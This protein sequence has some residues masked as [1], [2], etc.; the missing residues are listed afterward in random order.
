MGPNN[1]VGRASGFD[2]AKNSD[3]NNIGFSDKP[4]SVVVTSWISIC[5]AIV[6]SVL[7]WLLDASTT[8]SYAT[9]QKQKDQVIASINSSEYTQIDQKVSGF[10]SAY[11]EIL[12]ASADKFVMNVFLSSLYKVINTDV[13]IRNISITAD[14]KLNIDGVAESY[15]A[16]SDQML[17]L[18]SLSSLENVTLL[19][20]SMSTASSGKTEV[21]F[22]F[23]ADINKVSGS[24][25]N[26]VSLNAVDVLS[27]T[28]SN[29]SSGATTVPASA[30][31][32]SG[33]TNATQQ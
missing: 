30:I 15:R 7:F 17:S 18:K 28:N 29:S 24:K 19:S 14:G 21:P 22:V 6:V 1:I 3:F 5:V 32:Q 27:N 20:T 4:S 10:K 23:G 13:S 8:S 33:G 26:A 25:A 9:K 12:S 2:N 31:N 11:D 16:V